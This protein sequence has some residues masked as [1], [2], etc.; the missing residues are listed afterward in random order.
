MKTIRSGFLS[1]RCCLVD[2]VEQD[3]ERE[4][5]IT[6]EAI[7]DCYGPEEQA[8]GWYYYFQDRIAFQSS[9]PRG[10]LYFAPTRRRRGKR[11][12]HG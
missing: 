4:Y 1:L 6:M 8:M 5:R 10:A 11:R 9:V 2:K 3:E 12:E 7:V